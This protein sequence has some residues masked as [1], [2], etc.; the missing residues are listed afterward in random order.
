M[1]TTVENPFDT[2]QQK[3]ANTGIVSGAMQ[4]AGN[5]TGGGM[6]GGTQ[7]ATSAPADGQVS[8]FQAATRTIDPAK[9]TV[10]GQVDSIL[11]SDSPLMQ[12]ARTMATQ[13]MAQRGLVNSSMAVGAGQAAMVDRA[14]PIAAQDANTYNQ[15][16]SDNMAASNQAGMFN[17]GEQNR[18]GLQKSDQNFSAQQ[19]DINRQFQTGERVG[20][21][22]FQAGQNQIQLGFQERMAKLQ[23][24]GQDFRQARD[25]AS[26]EAITQLEQAGITNRFD[27]ELALKSDMF[28]V[29]QINADRRLIEQNSFDLQKLGLQLDAQ[30]QDIPTAFA[31]NISNTTMQGV[32]AIM[33]DGNL[34]ATAKQGAID[35]LVKYANSQ[36]SWA[37]T[38]YGTYIPPI[39]TP[40]VA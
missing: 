29:E 11:A 1:A 26:R 39:T 4:T 14:T 15:V 40:P 22:D 33:A 9:Q 27:Q 7:Y 5:M 18:F 38:F 20:A 28:N 35:N 16:A 32:N 13:Q 17:A 3:T 31:A 2:Q 19:A 25:I 21:Q 10:A 34:A 12:R 24:A 6:T 30:R 36:I 37:S 23:E 8:Q